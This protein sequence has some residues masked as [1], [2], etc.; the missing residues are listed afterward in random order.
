VSEVRRWLSDEQL[1]DDRMRAWREPVLGPL[2]DLAVDENVDQVRSVAVEALSLASGADA[3][4]SLLAR[5]SE[6]TNPQSRVALAQALGAFEDEASKAW[7]V[8]A[9]EDDALAVRLAAASSLVRR[10]PAS[11]SSWVSEMLLQVA[12][13]NDDLNKRREAG[14]ILSGLS[15]GREMLCAPV[16]QAL[17][18]DPSEAL[19]LIRDRVEVL[20]EDANLPWWEGHARRALGQFE[21]AIEAFERAEALEPQAPVI[22]LALAETLM[23]VDRFQAA[24]EAAARAVGIEPAD[25]EAQAQLAWASYKAGS[26][27]AAIRAAGTSTALDP[28][29]PLPLCVELLGYLRMQEPDPARRALDGLRRVMEFIGPGSMREELGFVE[30][31]LASVEAGGM[32]ADI[33]ELL[34][35]LPSARE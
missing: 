26:L 5:A 19:E 11:A 7:L 29:L 33:R 15:G 9:L 20:P 35:G 13:G 27:D 30:T 23:E 3:S 32:E 21:D 8:T 12:V 4:R 2:A 25:A 10:D 14:R 28:T 22:P 18:D 31:E 24:S 6:A 16:Q 1:G 34:R 17:E